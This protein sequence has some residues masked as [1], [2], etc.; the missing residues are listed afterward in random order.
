MLLTNL[1]K[2][3]QCQ[4]TSRLSPTRNDLHTSTPDHGLTSLLTD[5][6]GVQ[7]P[8]HISLS[9]ALVLTTDNKDAF[10][11]D[12]RQAL[13]TAVRRLKSSNSTGSSNASSLSRSL[14]VKLAGQVES[15]C[16]FLQTRRFWVVPVE[17]DCFALWTLHDAIDVVAKKYG[18][19]TLYSQ[20]KQY[21]TLPG[22]PSTQTAAETKSS[23]KAQTTMRS[24]HVPHEPIITESNHA[25][26]S[27]SD[28]KYSKANPVKEHPQ[29][30]GQTVNTN[31]QD[32]KH[33]GP[34][35][36]SIAWSIPSAEASFALPKDGTRSKHKSASET[37]DDEMRDNGN[38]SSQLVEAP[39]QL[40]HRVPDLEILFEDVKIRLGQ[41]VVSIPF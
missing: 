3:L 21:T 4:A 7:L 25:L 20:H 38:K 37:R 10:L 32:Q 9:A 41:D 28:V 11:A 29:R 27:A 17:E 18:C 39:D 15:H 19:H 16:N 24:D 12:M 35:H 2:S 36:I 6:L 40:L 13:K 31:K 14:S 22:S 8:L 1:V 5:S 30:G 34:F 26:A 33:T 23:N